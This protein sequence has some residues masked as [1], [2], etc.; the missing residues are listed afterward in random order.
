MNISNRNYK[1]FKFEYAALYYDIQIKLK[2]PKQLILTFILTEIG[3]TW[4]KISVVDTFVSVF[5]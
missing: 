4:P 5:S 2:I 1:L 3:T